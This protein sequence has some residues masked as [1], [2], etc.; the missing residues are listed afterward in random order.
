LLIRQTKVRP[1]V[2]Q[3]KRVA[4][5]GCLGAN[6]YQSGIRFCLLHGPQHFSAIKWNISRSKLAALW[7]VLPSREPHFSRLQPECFPFFFVAHCFAF[8]PPTG[9]F[10]GLIKLA[11]RCNCRENF[12]AFPQWSLGRSYTRY[13][14]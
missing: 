13:L 12:F 3:S 1:T 8:S 14:E 6:L 4:F 10:G 7:K 2:C 9:L 5:D 11:P